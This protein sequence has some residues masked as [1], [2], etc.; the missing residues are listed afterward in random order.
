M[1]FSPHKDRTCR[2]PVRDIVQAGQGAAEGKEPAVETPAK[3][4]V[5]EQAKDT[6]VVDSVPV[7]NGVAKVEKQ[8]EGKPAE[9]EKEKKKKKYLVDEE[10]LL[11]F[12]YFD[13]NCASLDLFQGFL[14]Y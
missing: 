3:E 5:G 6:K 10:L 4:S 1:L 8:E 14:K 9:K 12:R 2:N 13:R 7:E 11:A